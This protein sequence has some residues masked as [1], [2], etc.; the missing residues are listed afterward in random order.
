VCRLLQREFGET[1]IEDLPLPYY[2]VSA[3]LTTGQA[4]AH[5]RG[6]LWFWLRASVAIPG[7]LPPVL[8]GKQVFVDGATINNLPVDLM[9]E[10]L[11]GSVMAVDVGADRAFGTEIESTEMPAL[12]RIASWRRHRRAKINIMQV[13]WRSGMINS[14]ATTIGQR[15]LT[16]LLLRPSLDG[17]DLLDWQAFD[18]AIELGYRCAI[19]ALDKR[20][21]ARG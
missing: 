18:R 3:N 21:R 20:P 9:H 2:C 19:G 17:I 5:R 7:V 15:N 13:L 10:Q 16:D 14:A 4:A 1:D 8:T 12:W 6:K 11:R